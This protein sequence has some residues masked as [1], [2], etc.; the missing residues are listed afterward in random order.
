MRNQDLLKIYIVTEI[1]FKLEQTACYLLSRCFF[2]WVD[3]S[4][5]KMKATCPPETSVDF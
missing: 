4:T 1:K 5:L 3:S 2:F